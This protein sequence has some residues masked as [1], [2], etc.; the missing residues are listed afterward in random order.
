MELAADIRFD[1][2]MAQSPWLAEGWCEP[3]EAFSWTIG[4]QSRLRLDVPGAGAYVL[5]LQGHPLLHPERL[6][7]QRL[8]VAVNGHT[9]A[10]LHTDG[11]F[12]E[13]LRIPRGVIT[14]R[15]ADIIFS[16]PDSRAPASFGG[17]TDTRQL[18][19]RF[20]RIMLWRSGRGRAPARTPPQAAP[21]SDD[22][23]AELAA[24]AAETG[25]DEAER[26]MLAALAAPRPAFLP[27]P[28]TDL[29]FRKLFQD[30][31]RAGKLA[32]ASLMARSAA[33]FEGVS[34][35][36]DATLGAD[37]SL[38]RFTKTAHGRCLI[39]LSPML[40]ASRV[41][42]A[43]HEM[44]CWHLIA[45]LPVFAAYAAGLRPAGTSLVSLGDEGHTRGVAFCSVRS[46]NVVLIP[47]A[48]FLAS[49]GYAHQRAVAPMAWPAR[50]AIALWRG[51]STGYCRDG[52]V[53]AL[54]R[55]RLCAL[56]QR[57]GG[58][59]DAGITGFV[60]MSP[61]QAAALRAAGMA[62]D[63]VPAHDFSAWKYHIDID[64]NTNSW[65]GL[66]QKLLSGGAVL[67]VAS[68]YR[69]WYYP[70][71]LPFVHYVPVAADLSDLPARLHVL[72][73]NDEVARAIGEAGRALALE[74]TLERE[75]AAALEALETAVLVET[76]SDFP[77]P[78]AIESRAG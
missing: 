55:V 62:R 21:P 75:T 40:R 77:A 65:P 32:A 57:S 38:A 26:A 51:S 4:L 8:S 67:K 64:G 18:G 9:L 22:G 53:F 29:L 2:V 60:Q 73:G 23:F 54:P 36:I 27:A 20:W 34:L 58:T 42:P 17:S 6:P 39:G 30:S 1:R 66:F 72:R 78:A 46:M 41:M 5:V 43:E 24:L 15:R 49:G 3:E 76:Y 68:A 44:L 10:T 71:L 31:L 19:I 63:F 50:R 48:Y 25:R 45:L 47:D 52:D 69:Q 28:A 14:G 59:I 37:A 11:L 13:R 35:C 61:A 56:A 7:A 33:G 74:M 70:R 16:L 12:T